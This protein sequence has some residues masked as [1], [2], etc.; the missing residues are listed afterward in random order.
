MSKSISNTFV[1]IKSLKK[2]FYTIEVCKNKGERVFQSN[3]GLLIHKLTA[4]ANLVNVAGNDCA[5]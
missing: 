4:R 2:T 1:K 5:C 3:D